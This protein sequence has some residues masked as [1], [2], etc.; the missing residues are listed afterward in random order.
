MKEGKNLI[1]TAFLGIALLAFSYYNFVSF[2]PKVLKQVT[3]VKGARATA[4]DTLPY[5]TDADKIGINQTGNLK[6]TTFQTAKTP[7]EVQVFY[8]NVFI[9]Y[10][11]DL[12]IEGKN[13]S[14]LMAKYRKD[15]KIATIVTSKQSEE[16]ATIASIEIVTPKQK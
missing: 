15:K 6:L 14:V 8:K 12:D 4:E 1:L 9:E 10:G 7:E 5:P 13:D 11:W 2:Q 16:K 3:E